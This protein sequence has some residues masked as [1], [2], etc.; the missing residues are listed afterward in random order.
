MVTITIDGRSL[1]VP[2]RTTI[3]DAARIAGIRIPTLCYMKNLNEIGACRVC[4]VEVEGYDR[5]MTACNNTVADGMVIRTNSKKALSA[6]RTNVQLILS[7][8]NTACTTCVR[9]GNCALQKIASELNLL[10]NP[11]PLRLPKQKGS[12]TFPLIRDYQKCIK[13]MR[14]VQ[15]CDKIQNTHIWDV[16]NT[17][18]QTSVD[19]TGVYS[20]EDSACAL[21]GQCITHCPVGALHERDD[22]MKVLEAVSD[23]EVVTVVQIAPSI[24]TA[25]GETFGMSPDE[26]TVGRLAAAL[27][28][29][30]VDYVF[31]SDFSADLTIMEEANEFLERLK[32]GDAKQFPMFTSCCPGWVRFCKAHYPQFVDRISTSKSPQQM[33]GAMIK[34]YFAERINVDPSKICSISIMPCLAKKAECDYPTMKDAAGNAD[35]DLVLTTREAERLI[36]MAHI[37][38]QD[39]PDEE[40]DSPLGIGSGAGNIFGASGGVMEAALRTAYYAVNGENPD[41]DH[42]R[43]VRG[44]GGWKQAVFDL[45]GTQLRVAVVNG[46][47]NASALL[48]A[49]DCGRVNYDFVE[50]MACPGGCVGG[51][52]QPIHDGV[53]MAG[54]R[55]PVLYRQDRNMTLRFSH[56]NPAIQECYR[57][58][59][60]RP[61]SERAEELLHTDQHGWKMPGETFFSRSDRSESGKDVRTE[62]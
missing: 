34:S 36:R 29:I 47:G 13:C 30:G 28:R 8:H 25:W 60:G 2:E 61:L 24:R 22:T 52:G 32:G 12:R 11:Y 9:S 42:F 62:G 5:L 6:R 44:M 43:E 10:D 33:F 21:C 18:A 54:D 7:E 35:V 16:I 46:L 41:P 31:D 4:V 55:A 27:R 20:L 3:L 26:A 53:E 50:V 14:C 40:M 1:S 45:N 17:G 48:D 19:V 58:Y 51:G 39:L 57:E 59:L 38:P 56:D 23:P 37:V 15:V 49:L